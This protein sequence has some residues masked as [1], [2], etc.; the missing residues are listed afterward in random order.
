VPGQGHWW[1]DTKEAN[2]GGAVNDGEMRGFFTKILRDPSL[3][4]LPETFQ[5]TTT[6]PS[7]IGGRGGFSILQ[8]VYPQRRAVVEVGTKD[9]Q[10][11]ILRTG[12]VA[13]LG[14][15]RTVGRPRPTSLEV[16]GCPFVLPQTQLHLCRSSAADD[17]CR[18][19]ICVS[20]PDSYQR[21]E[22]GPQNSG[23][24]RQVF[25]SPFAIVYGTVGTRQEKQ[26][27]KEMAVL[28]ANLH[29]H[30]AD[31]SVLVVADSDL[32]DEQAG[33]INLAIVGGPY[34]NSWANRTSSAV[35]WESPEK[36]SIGGC[37]HQG[38]GLAFLYTTHRW[39]GGPRIDL[40]LA[41]TDPAGFDNLMSLSLPTIPPMV[42]APF[43]NQVPD[44]LVSGP[45]LAARGWGGIHA[46]GTWGNQ[47]EW[48][49]DLS[50]ISEL[51]C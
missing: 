15:E 8:L 7:A 4:P 32:T 46:A 11:W 34:H 22:R 30:A 43:T 40:V 45:N 21:F 35:V 9:P 25:E 28:L 48:R 36:A 23:P 5:L 37:L 38:A 10:R 47:W 20:P 3:P 12:N 39:A 17:L 29:Y 33:A 44:F 14:Y 50:Y 51:G 16:D 19:V 6:N 49:S 18:W 42:R 31:T 13:R 41:A 2:D 24:A 1:W 27:M 26:K